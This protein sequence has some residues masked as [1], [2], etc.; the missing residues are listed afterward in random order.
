MSVEPFS[1]AGD[2]A[3]LWFF[4]ASPLEL[5]STVTRTQTA[6]ISHSI[7]R[8]TI[9]TLRVRFQEDSSSLVL[10]F[11]QFFSIF[12]AE[13]T[14]TATIFHPQY[15]DISFKVAAFKTSV[16][17]QRIWQKMASSTRNRQAQA[18]A[19]CH[20]GPLLGALYRPKATALSTPW[21][22]VPRTCANRQPSSCEKLDFFGPTML[23][24]PH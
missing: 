10:F 16:W 4:S 15:L 18:H 13:Q 3:R 20:T 22:I 21:R 17:A 11:F 19:Q 24:T 5:A 12:F 14:P 2:V 6:F 9:I 1:N 7:I 23:P 8:Y